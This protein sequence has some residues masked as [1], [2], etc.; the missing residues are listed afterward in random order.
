[1]CCTGDSEPYWDRILVHTNHTN[2]C[3]ISHTNK[4]IKNGGSKKKKEWREQ[5]FSMSGEGF[6]N[7]KREKTIKNPVIFN[8]N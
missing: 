4:Y 5:S 1:M 7:T 2:K 8:W 3:M 6:A